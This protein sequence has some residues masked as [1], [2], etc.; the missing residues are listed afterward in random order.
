MGADVLLT[1][2]SIAASISLLAAAGEWI[3]LRRRKKDDYHVQANSLRDTHRASEFRVDLEEIKRITED[4]L[5]DPELEPDLRDFLMRLLIMKGRG[6]IEVERR[7]LVQSMELLEGSAKHKILQG[8]FFSQDG[9]AGRVR[10]IFSVEDDFQERELDP[11]ITIKGPRRG[12]ARAEYEITVEP[13]F[14]VELLNKTD[15]VIEKI[16]HSFEYEGEL[17]DVDVFRGINHGLVIAEIE[18]THASEVSKPGWCGE[19]VTDER[20]YNNEELAKRPYTTWS[21]SEKNSASEPRRP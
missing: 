5:Y 21:V 1:V 14:A 17:W 20:R 9:Y 13:S 11:T 3:K 12:E 10:R 2:A 15:N 6:G 4:A 8:Y 18:T 19:E 7:F 16:R